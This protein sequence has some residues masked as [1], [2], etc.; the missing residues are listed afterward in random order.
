MNREFSIESFIDYCDDMMIANE[1]AVKD[2]FMKNPMT[3]A[4]FVM[5][6]V[7]G[8]YLGG[9]MVKTKVNKK[10]AE[11][12]QNTAKKSTKTKP[13]TVY[14]L[15]DT[16]MEGVFKVSGKVYPAADKAEVLRSFALSTPG[17]IVDRG[18]VQINDTVKSILNKKLYLYSL[19]STNVTMQH[20]W[21][22]ATSDM[23]I[24][25]VE[26]GTYE[27]LLKS[28]NIEIEI[29]KSDVSKRRQMI[30]KYSKEIYDFLK[31]SGV[32]KGIEMVT[33]SEDN[34]DF[35]YGFFDTA[36]LVS[37]DLWDFNPQARTD[38]DKNNIFYNAQEKILKIMNEKY[39]DI[40]F[41]D[42]CDWDGGCFEMTIKKK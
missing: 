29:I 5:L 34:D 1:G 24:K 14:M 10:K 8:L 19:D 17:A 3:G 42:G 28:Y 20:P 22:V 37:W 4:G 11:R 38:D 25:N 33:D 23:Q 41:D 26:E 36:Y 21:L 6:A 27:E 39:P 40:E 2:A 32:D 13:N 31:Q 7:S 16:K 30:K 12:K 15:S 18:V 35:I 9:Q